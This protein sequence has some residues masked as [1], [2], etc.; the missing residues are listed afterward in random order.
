MTQSA[1]P[2]LKKGSVIINTTSV[3]AFEG[4]KQL[5]DYNS[6]KGA[7]LTFAK[8]LSQYLISKVIRVNSVA[9]QPYEIDT[10]YLFLASDDSSYMSW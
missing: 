10:C 5:I 6:T 2:Y 9:V 7:I 4:N 8:Y 3:T 1:L